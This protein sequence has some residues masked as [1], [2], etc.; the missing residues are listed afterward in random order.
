MTEQ[1]LSLRDR[2]LSF[3]DATV[4]TRID[5]I[6]E[7][8]DRRDAFEE[9]N[10][11]NVDDKSTSYSK[12]KNKMLSAQVAVARFTLALDIEPS[13][14]IE[15]KV[16]ESKMFNAKALEKVT[17][18][19]LFTVGKG[20]DKI[21]SVSVAF[22]ACALVFH[23]DAKAIDNTV[24]KLFLSNADVSKLVSDEKI[25]D[26]VKDYQHKF[27][28]GGKDTQSSQV[29]CALEVLGLATIA[30]ETRFRGGIKLHA[31]HDFFAAFADRYMK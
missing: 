12:A 5:A 9:R 1:T 17:E 11:L 3:D 20:D 21:Q 29:R 30:N 25:A 18:F 2:A 8:F 26:Y 14:I 6:I 28:T 19:A 27:M 4:E 10:G 13:A 31:D 22:I 15:R 16:V 7:S 24:N 23:D